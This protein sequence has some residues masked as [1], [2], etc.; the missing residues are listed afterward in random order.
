VVGPFFYHPGCLSLVERRQR[1]T[2]QSTVAGDLRSRNSLGPD[3]SGMLVGK[4]R[5]PAR[6][7]KAA[8]REDIYAWAAGAETASSCGC[9]KGSPQGGCG[10]PPRA[11]AIQEAASGSLKGGGKVGENSSGVI[12]AGKGGGGVWGGTDNP[13][14]HCRLRPRHKSI[15]F[16]KMSSRQE[17]GHPKPGSPKSG[18]L[19]V[20]KSGFK[21]TTCVWSSP[22]VGPCGVREH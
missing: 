13:R 20:R 7:C 17:D 19:T 1:R 4:L 8:Q 15:F 12:A 21:R 14:R 10:M 9:S 11:C 22:A 5:S 2:R 18:H 3:G 16:A 6:R